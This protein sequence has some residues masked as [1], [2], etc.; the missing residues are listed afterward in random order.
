M[1][2]LTGEIVRRHRLA[3]NY[4]YEPAPRDRLV[5]VARRVGG[6]QAQVLSAAELAIGARV[7]GITRQDVQ[8]ELWER[9]GL[10][11][12]YGPRG[13]LHLLPADELPLWMAALRRCMEWR[14]PRWYAALGLGRAQ[15]DALIE[16][17]GEA[18]DGRLLSRQ[19]LAEA[20]AARVGEWAREQIIPQWGYC[21]A[22]AA[23]AGQLCFGPSRGSQVTYARPDQWAGYGHEPDPDEALAE[24]CRRYLEAYGPATLRDL[25]RWIGVK[26]AEAWR[27]K[28]LLPARGVEVDV[29]GQRAWVMAGEVTAAEE[30]ERDSLRLLP[31][32]DCYVLGCGPRS[33]IVPD[34][35]RARILGYGRG[36]FEGATGVPVLLIDGVVAGVWERRKRGRGIELRVEA[37]VDLGQAQRRLLEDEVDRIGAFL[38]AE[39]SLQL[40]TLG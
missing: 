19:E 17:I 20:V 9:R 2:T 25:A 7:A 4:L 27:L 6:I 8:A 22:P 12:T 15:A 40:G 21:L 23:F 32:Y 39:T 37:F 18:L 29:G 30:R 31:Q 11:K 34:A 13:T 10:V 35:A 5:E 14:E 3:R 26:P 28:E 38:G 16:G 33:G 36:R 1:T 24:V